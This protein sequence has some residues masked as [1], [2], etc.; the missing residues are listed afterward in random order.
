MK[1]IKFKPSQ[2]PIPVWGRGRII[3]HT[4]T[5]LVTISAEKARALGF[6]REYPMGRGLPS[7]ARF[8]A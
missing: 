7:P 6:L 3:G 1:G 5:G 2:T 8:P 4:G